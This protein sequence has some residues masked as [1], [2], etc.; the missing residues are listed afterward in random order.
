MTP[1]WTLDEIAAACDGTRVGAA[2]P[3]RPV[4]GV[5]FDSREVASGDLYIARRGAAQDGH[6]FIA[7]ALAAGAAAILLEQVEALPEGAAGICVADSDAALTA[8]GA[9]GRAR[10][11]GTVIG[12]TGSVAKTG[13]KEALRQC[14]ERYRPGAVHA[15]VK[16]YNN[17]TGV[18]LS[19][20][21]M[22]RAA[23][24]GVFEMGMNHAGELS[25]LTRLVRPHVALITTVASAHIEFFADGEPGIARAK[26]EIFEG[27]EPG[28]TAVI[29]RDNPHYPIM[30]K[31]AQAS[32]AGQILTFAVNEPSANVRV[33]SA[34]PFAT[35]TAVTA[36][37]CGDMLTFKIG[38]P[39]AH[40]VANAL[41]VLAC[42]KAAGADLGLA[43]LALAELEELDG[44]GKRLLVAARGG[45]ALVLD[46]SYNANPAS[47]AAALSVIGGLERSGAGRRIAMLGDMKELGSGSAAMHRGLA[48]PIEEAD[49]DVVVTVGAEMGRLKDVLPRGIACVSLDTAEQAQRWVQDNL[50][51]DDLLLVKGSNSMG[52]GRIVRHLAARPREE[53]AL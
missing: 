23:K 7:N 5:T 14:L 25:A 53:E 52:L 10:M 8:L 45:S 22:L 40:W 18:P 42:V 13:C 31:A 36:L 44:R 35:G 43:G 41:A 17:H 20:A 27:L 32:Q 30:L 16:S 4:S 11:N 2:G 49:I 48:D 26:S 19:L 33:L 34:R 38:L 15:S 21:R 1:L 51:A 3:G 46:E 24:F 50:R 39:G 37:V 47:V 12:V 29:N 6:G 28:G 9:A